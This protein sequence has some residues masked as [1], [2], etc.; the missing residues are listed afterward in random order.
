LVSFYLM[1]VFK[2]VPAAFFIN[3]EFILKTPQQN[4]IYIS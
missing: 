3:M 2:V 4:Q 1:N